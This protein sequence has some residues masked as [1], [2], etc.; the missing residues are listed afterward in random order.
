MTRSDAYPTPTRVAALVYFPD[1]EEDW[2][3]RAA[4][5]LL[6]VIRADDPK[7]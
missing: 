6:Y 3:P 5:K 7:R 1:D 4:T 2:I